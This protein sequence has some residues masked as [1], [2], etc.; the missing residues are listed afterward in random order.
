MS[1]LDIIILIPIAF[2]LIRGLVRGFV[3]ELTAVVAI[4]A[5]VVCAKIYAPSFGNIL[6]DTFTWNQQVC[7]IVAYM[8]IFIGVALLLHVVAKLI[9]KLLRT[10]SLG[11]LNCLLGA[12]LGTAKWAIL[13]SVLLVAFNALD[14]RFQILKPAQKQSSVLYEPV[15]RIA[16]IAWEAVK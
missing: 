4:V 16:G 5:G 13:V 10:I 8:L 12:V 6:T 15:G 3:V 9:S 7:N 11:W 14:Q 1:W 2:G